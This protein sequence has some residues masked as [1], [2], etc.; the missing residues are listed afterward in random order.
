[1]KQTYDVVTK[2][3]MKCFGCRYFGVISH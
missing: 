2:N 1:M 3:S